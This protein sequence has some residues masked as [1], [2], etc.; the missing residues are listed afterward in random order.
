MEKTCNKC[1][2]IKAISDFYKH[3]I[4]KDGYTSVCKE[5]TKASVNKYAE[6]NRKTTNLKKKIWR[7]NNPDKMQKYYSKWAKNNGKKLLRNGKIYRDKNKEK[8][9]AHWKVAKAIKK[10]NIIKQPCSICGKK[11]VAHHPNYSLP[12][13]VVWF[14]Q[15]HH[16]EQHSK[17]KLCQQKN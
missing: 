17:D 9:S 15:K 10:G 5:C 3:S 13:D 16:I 12:L 6:L 2:Q 7:E 4:E 14:C 11:A 8:A 1:K